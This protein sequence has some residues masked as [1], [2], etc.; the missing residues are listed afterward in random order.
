MGMNMS[1]K[2]DLGNSDH[3]HHTGC[4]HT[5]EAENSQPAHPQDWVLQESQFGAEGL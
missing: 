2:G 3:L 4:L 5:G 1:Y